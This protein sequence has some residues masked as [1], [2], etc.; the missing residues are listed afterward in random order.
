MLMAYTV[1]VTAISRIYHSRLIL[2]KGK[3]ERKIARESK[4]MQLN[5]VE[6]FDDFI[7]IS[8]VKFLRKLEENCGHWP[9]SWW[10][11]TTRWRVRLTRAES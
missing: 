9:H 3:K 8:C 1:V 10:L 11:S 7:A 5:N 6:R 2:F 4:A